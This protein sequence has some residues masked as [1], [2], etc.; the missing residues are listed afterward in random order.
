LAG[1]DGG[2]SSAAESHSPAGIP[3]GTHLDRSEDERRR[4]D[5]EQA[6]AIF[7]ERCIAAGDHRGA[8]RPGVA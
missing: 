8:G 1:N 2:S 4:N 3:E 7:S 5:L 6:K